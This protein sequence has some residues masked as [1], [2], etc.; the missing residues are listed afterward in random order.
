MGVPTRHGNDHG[1]HDFEEGGE[2][3]GSSDALA[4]LRPLVVLLS[5]EE[6]QKG[7]DRGSIAALS[8]LALKEGSSGH[9]LT[10]TDHWV[11]P[12]LLEV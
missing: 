12:R 4:V 11:V 6:G 5:E 8:H 10:R 7:I 1:V 3:M 9:I 2:G